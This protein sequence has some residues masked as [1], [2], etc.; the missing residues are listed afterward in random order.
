[1]S[2]LPSDFYL[3][4][5]VVELSRELIGKVICSNIDGKLCKA[6]ITETE[7]YAG[8]VDKA[9]HAYKGRRTNRTEIMYAGGGVAY[10]YLC[11]GIHYL[12]NVVS[13]VEGIPH[14]VLIRGI[15]PL[16]NSDQMLRRRKAAS[17]KKELFNGPAK[18]TQALGISISHNGIDLIGDQIWIED[19][20]FS[21]DPSDIETTTR[22]GIDYAEEDAKLPYRFFLKN[23]LKKFGD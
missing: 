7:A 14:A 9:S 22:I 18:V 1:M 2:K 8:V 23:D 4:E 3:K 12:F 5:D 17:F 16:H 21:I 13:N 6:I 20:Q 15:Y 19:H 10:V 11:Y